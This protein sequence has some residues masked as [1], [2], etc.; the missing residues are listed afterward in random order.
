MRNKIGLGDSSGD[1]LTLAIYKLMLENVGTKY[2]ATRIIEKVYLLHSEDSN[3][4]YYRKVLRRLNWLYANDFVSAKQ[5]N[6]FKPI[7]WYI[8]TD[9]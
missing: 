2:A 6:K 7:L 4:P 8:S 9:Y 1:W 5:V 3:S